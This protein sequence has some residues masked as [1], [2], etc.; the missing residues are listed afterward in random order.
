MLLKF[1]ELHNPLFLSGTN[2]GTKLDPSKRSGLLLEYDPKKRML[3]VWFNQNLSLVPEPSVANMVP[4]N[5]KD[6]GYTEPGLVF[7]QVKPQE[8]PQPNSEIVAQVSTPHSHVFAAE[9]GH[10]GQEKRKK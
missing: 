5:I 8:A 10:T 6:T 1:V 4:V 3:L 2:L 9:P 7:E